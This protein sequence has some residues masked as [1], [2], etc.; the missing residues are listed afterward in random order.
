LILYDTRDDVP[1][2]MDKW[3]ET[4][5]RFPASWPVVRLQIVLELRVSRAT[6]YRYLAV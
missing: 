2:D 3:R 1:C 6:L 5:A 4:R